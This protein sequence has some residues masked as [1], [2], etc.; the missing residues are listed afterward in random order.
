MKM[1]KSFKERANFDG[2]IALAF[3]HH[4]AIGKIFL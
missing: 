1:R 3:E 2:M 4:L